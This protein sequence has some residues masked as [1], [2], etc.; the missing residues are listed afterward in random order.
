MNKNAYAEH[1]NCPTFMDSITEQ[2]KLLFTLTHLIAM[3][4]CTK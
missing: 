4:S 1:F 2:R 3:F